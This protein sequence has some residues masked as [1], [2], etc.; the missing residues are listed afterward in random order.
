MEEA[1]Q[2]WYI[3]LIRCSDETLYTGIS[4]DVERRFTEH[5]TDGAR[6]ARYLRGRGPLRLVF[7]RSVGDRSVALRLEMK[8]K[9]LSRTRKEQ[10]ITRTGFFDRILQGIIDEPA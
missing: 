1:Q 2:T 7:H 4:T 9:R 6:G 8:I 5:Q 10:L 3:Y